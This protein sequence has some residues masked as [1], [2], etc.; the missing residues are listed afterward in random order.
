MLSASISYL[1]AEVGGG[2]KVSRKGFHHY[3]YA[4]LP[5]HSVQVS[6][7]DKW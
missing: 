3:N 4:I 2:G 1:L 7:P 5:V 6:E